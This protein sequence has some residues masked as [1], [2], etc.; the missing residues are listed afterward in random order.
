MRQVWTEGPFFE[1]RDH[2]FRPLLSLIRHWLARIDLSHLWGVFGATWPN[3][4][5]CRFRP[6]APGLYLQALWSY[7]S[8]W[9]RARQ[10]LCTT[11]PVFLR[12]RRWHRWA[13]RSASFAYRRHLR[14]SDSCFRGLQFLSSFS[15]PWPRLPAFECWDLFGVVRCYRLDYRYRFPFIWWCLGAW[16]RSLPVR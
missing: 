8:F 7:C 6:P 12:D 4:P 2:L 3:R 14:V 16:Q 9:P 5:A 10:C 1:P 13:V 15:L 11:A